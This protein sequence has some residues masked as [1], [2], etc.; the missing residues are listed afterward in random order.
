MRL[1]KIA[2]LL[3]LANQP[4]VNTSPAAWRRLPAGDYQRALATFNMFDIVSVWNEKKVI[5]LIFTFTA[6]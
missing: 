3:A 1:V 6:G 4:R 2:F 5:V